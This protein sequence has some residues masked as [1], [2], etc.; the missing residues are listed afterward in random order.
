MFHAKALKVWTVCTFI[1]VALWSSIYSEHRYAPCFMST[2]EV[3]D[4]LES[5]TNTFVF[6][7]Q[8]PFP[9]SALVAR[10]RRPHTWRIHLRSIISVFTSNQP[11]PVISALNMSIYAQE[12]RSDLPDLCFSFPPLAKCLKPSVFMHA[13]TFKHMWYKLHPLRCD[14]A[15]TLKSNELWNLAMSA[16]KCH[17]SAWSVQAAVI[18]L[19]S[20]PLF[21][22]FCLCI[23]W[24]S[25]D[26]M[27]VSGTVA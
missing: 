11:H 21:S 1:Y 2:H 9:L 7:N 18:F 13:G 19:S 26:T 6:Q 24:V 8:Q 25:L 5:I 12:S 14:R 17:N 4:T 23:V 22:F 3:S 20:F 27:T 15:A 16:S 10:F